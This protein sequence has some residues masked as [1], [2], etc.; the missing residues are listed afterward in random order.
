MSVKQ[1][2]VTSPGEPLAVVLAAGRGTRMGSDLPKVA[3]KAA[4][5]PLVRWVIDALAAA[6]VRDTIVVVGHRA[7]VVEEALAGLPGLAFALQREQRGTGDAVRAAA[8]LIESRLPDAP[9]DASRPVVIVCG[10][11]PMLRPASVTSLLEE[12]ARRRASCLLGTAITADA[13]GLGRIVRGPDG[14][15]QRIVEERDATPAERSIREVNMSTYVFDARDLLAALARLDDANAA[16]EYYLTDCPALLLAAGKVVDA[17]ACLDD[18]E[19]LSVN[20]PE[21]LAAVAATLATRPGVGDSGM[22]AG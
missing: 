14:R 10:D 18:S 2:A 6:G 11:S 17:V 5:K 16:G 4:G 1:A 7:E 3:F 13:A 21:Q 12:F 9:P 20:T 19:T 15:F 22:T 8:G